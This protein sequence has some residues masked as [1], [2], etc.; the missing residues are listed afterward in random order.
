MLIAERS[1]NM[2][3]KDDIFKEKLVELRTNESIKRRRWTEDDDLILTEKFYA[4]LG[5]S[6]ISLQLH[7]TEPAVFNRI[8]KLKLYPKKIKKKA[9]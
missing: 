4:G 2:A 3:R 5:I 9:E 8:Q 6:L 1:G 7:R